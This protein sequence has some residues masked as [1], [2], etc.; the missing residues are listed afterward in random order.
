MSTKLILI[1]HGETDWTYQKRYCSSTDIDL[2]ETG[3]N[4]AEQLSEILRREKV[5]MVYSSDMKRTL[6]F[7]RIVFKDTPVEEVREFREMNFGIFESLTYEAIMD[8]YPK[9]YSKWLDNP[10]DTVLPDGESLSELAERIRNA[11]VKIISCNNDK[12]VAV[13]THAG[14]IRVI[15]CD[16]LKLDLNDIWQVKSD[17]ASMNIIEYSG[18]EGEIRLLNDT[19]H[20]PR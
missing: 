8:K 6:Q 16:V 17:L 2:N 11:L 10:C 12:T 3:R 20:L 14:P 9:I 19:S 4:Q 7:T 13:F 1:R 15:L 5:Y 18:K